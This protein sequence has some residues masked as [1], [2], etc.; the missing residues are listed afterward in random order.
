M[1]NRL[2]VD[3]LAILVWGVLFLRL[4]LTGQLFLLIHPNYKL[5]T[6]GAGFCLLGLGIR[7]LFKPQQ[8]VL[9]N[10][11]LPRQWS[12][13]LLLMTGILG[14]VIPPRPFASD[15]AFQRGIDDSFAVVRGAQTFRRSN[16]PEQRTI[17]E[18]VRTLHVYPEPDAYRG[19]KVDVTGFVVHP[20]GLPSNY[21]LISRFVITCCAADVYPVGLLVKLENSDRTGYPPDRWLRIKGVMDTIEW[22]G[23]RK[24][25]IIPQEIIP[26]SPPPN[27]YES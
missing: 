14:L 25:A 20:S 21:F 19:Q 24:L 9:H 12:S 2:T 27:P 5:L 26:V 7:L 1:T 18:W 6:I 10:N 11:L 15:I 23:K 3:T 8:T 17:V 22:Q 4:W 16:K 13:G